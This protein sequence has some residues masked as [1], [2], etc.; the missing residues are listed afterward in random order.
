MEGGVAVL[1]QAWRKTIS[2]LLG[3]PLWLLLLLSMGL[4]VRG[5]PVL[6]LYGKRSC[7]CGR[8]ASAVP[9]LGMPVSIGLAR[10]SSGLFSGL[11]LFPRHDS[12]WQRLQIQGFAPDPP[13]LRW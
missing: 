5:L 12:G 3:L 4:S 2:S 7:S 13:Q 9:L 11:A 8:P 1:G 10:L 6:T